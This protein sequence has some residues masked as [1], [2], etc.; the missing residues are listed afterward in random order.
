MSRRFTFRAAVTAA[1]LVSA[2]LP[3]LSNAAVTS[4]GVPADGAS[5]ASQRVEPILY[6]PVRFANEPTWHTPLSIPEIQADAVGFRDYFLRSSNGNVDYKPEVANWVT[7]P[8]SAAPDLE[9][10]VCYQWD[11]EWQQK[12]LPPSFNW[13]SLQAPTLAALQSQQPGID[14]TKFK[15]FIFITPN[16]Y[17]GQVN[18]KDTF[19]ESC[20]A[21]LGYHNPWLYERNVGASLHEWMHAIG[22]NHGGAIKCTERDAAV[23]ANGNCSF[24]GTTDAT[25]AQNTVASGEIFSMNATHR[26]FTGMMSTDNVVQANTAVTADYT[27]TN[28]EETVSNGTKQVLKVPRGVTSGGG[29]S[30]QLPFYY[31]DYQRPKTG[32]ASV[33]GSSDSAL[34]GVSIRRAPQLTPGVNGEDQPRTV[35]PTPGRGSGDFTWNARSRFTSTDGRSFKRLD[36]DLT[37]KVGQSFW[38]AQA[39]LTITTKSLTTTTAT[40]TVKPGK[41]TAV[42]AMVSLTS[43]VLKAE[44]TTSNRANLV[45]SKDASSGKIYVADYGSAIRVTSPCVIENVQTA[46]CPGTGVTKL[47]LR[48]GSGD[49]TIAINDSVGTIPATLFGNAGNDSL[50]GGPGNDTIDGGLGA[51]AMDGGK[52]SGD[53]VSYAGRTVGILAKPSD[54]PSAVDRVQARGQGEGGENDGISYETESV[55]DAPPI[56]L[57]TVDIHTPA[58]RVYTNDPSVGMTFSANNQSGRTV[59]YECTFYGDNA[60]DWAPC[61]PGVEFRGNLSERVAAGRRVFDYGVRVLDGSTGIPLGIAKYRQGELLF[62]NA[63]PDFNITQE[64][65]ST[66]LP[67]T[68]ATFAFNTTD[69]PGDGCQDWRSQGKTCV[70]FEKSING[71]AWAEVDSPWNTGTLSAGTNRIQI[72]ARDLAGNVAPDSYDETF[73]VLPE[74]NIDSGPADNAWAKTSQLPVKYTF[75]SPNSG[76][77]GYKCWINNEPAAACTSPYTVPASAAD[78]VVRFGVRA[79]AGIIHGPIKYRNV[80]IDRIAP[81]VP[82]INSG[83]ANGST[84]TTNSATFTFSA[85]LATTGTAPVHVEY[86]L[87]SGT[88]TTPS[89]GDLQINNMSD[90]QHTF[91]VR[92]VD[93]SGNTSAVV[94][95]TFT[96]DAPA[97]AGT[98]RISSAAVPAASVNLTG[99][100]A[101]LD[102]VHWKGATNTN[103]DRASVSTA[104]IQ[105]WTRTGT[106]SIGTFTS[107]GSTFTWTNNKVSPTSGSS[108]LGVYTQPTT[109]GNG[110][111]VDVTTLPDQSLIAK[112]YVA[113]TGTSSSATFKATLGSQSVS[114][115]VSSTSTAITDR[116]FTVKFRRATASDKLTLS[117]VRTSGSPQVGIY[118][119]S[120]Q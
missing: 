50:E 98:V 48:G 75:S 88:W 95:R 27:I 57:P 3:A 49:D 72:R 8:R 39:D 64:P 9:N 42:G 66:M 56:Q 30:T 120:L 69:R 97:A 47:E 79:V 91:S 119:A 80:G 102:W 116:V 16:P 67:A 2:V 73:Y 117:W 110:F 28:I 101:S 65:S 40:V 7:I 35:N 103:A 5:F 106:T 84:I 32:F 89:T 18:G 85:A 62:D 37:L 61:S 51:D 34:R 41:P 86:L 53:R 93:E 21:G 115:V 1:A 6:V 108:N 58:G 11:P 12:G 112:F 44:Q 83:P 45:V 17:R 52:G 113:V 90:G 76:V 14:Q 4:P 24:V 68:G 60:G 10:T 31:V 114:S 26:L 43:G 104:R 20:P 96:V 25:D 54:T 111:N 87:D 55:V 78:G 92:A 63:A 19:D 36:P 100:P 74:V 94:S 13:S 118:G 105:P 15:R 82:T 99:S 38:D 70:V 29:T 81:A 46:S 77:T 59:S 71:G 33:A 109:N 22:V 23:P 107:P